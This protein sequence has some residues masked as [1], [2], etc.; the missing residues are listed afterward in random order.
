MAAPVLRD[1]YLRPPRSGAAGSEGRVQEAL[2]SCFTGRNV[3]NCYIQVEYGPTTGYGTTTLQTPTGPYHELPIGDLTPGT[4]YH[5]R[6]KATDPTDAGNPTYS[7]DY[8]FFQTPNDIPAGPIVTVG[9]PTSVLATSAVMNWSTAV[10]QPAGQ[11]QYGTTTTLVPR[12]VANET[13]GT[14]TTHTTPL[15]G[16]VTATRYYYRI[17]QPDA[18]GNVTLSGLRSFVTA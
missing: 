9:A 1:V 15:S 3:T 14:T 12:S 8:G 13:P 17:A 4:Y 5:A 11:V 10:A 7:T 18:A 6:V 2:V 16:L